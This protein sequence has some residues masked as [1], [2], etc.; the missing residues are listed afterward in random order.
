M[1]NNIVCHWHRYLEGGKKEKEK[2]EKNENI[3][4]K[5]DMCDIFVCAV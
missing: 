2:A 5:C 3:A 4:R 1:V